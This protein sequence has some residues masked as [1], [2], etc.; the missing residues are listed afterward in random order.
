MAS[1]LQIAPEPLGNHEPAPAAVVFE[2]V[3]TRPIRVVLADDH[4]LTRRTLRLLLDAE[5]DV[6][7]VAEAEDHMATV[8]HLHGHEPDVL[9]LDLS[10]SDGSGIETVRSLCA[11]V[12]QTRIVV[13]TMA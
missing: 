2:R 3:A 11:R 10:M 4:V 9:V 7:V 13:L 8:R 5:S 12:P 6:E 1:H